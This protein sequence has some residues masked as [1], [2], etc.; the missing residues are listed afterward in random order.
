MTKEK[1]AS[2]TKHTQE[3]LNRL[4]SPTP[5]KHK[6]HEVQYR[7]YLEQEVAMIKAKLDAARLEGVK[8]K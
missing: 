1:L 7:R 4:S 3:H 6:G 8:E 5:A 2:L